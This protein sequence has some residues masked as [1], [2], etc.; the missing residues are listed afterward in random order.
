MA[1]NNLSEKERNSSK[2][3]TM[4]FRIDSEIMRNISDEA[5]DAR[6]SVNALVNQILSRYSEWGVKERKAGMV[7]VSKQLIND[8]FRRITSEEVIMMAKDT[9][10][11]AVYNIALFMKGK[12]DTA[13]F[14]D[15]FLARMKTC[16]E[17]SSIT[18]DDD[19]QTYILKHDLGQNWSLYNKTVLELIFADLLQ[20]PLR[21]SI[22]DSTIVI[23]LVKT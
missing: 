1:S 17:I 16:S 18:E 14:L 11:N 7:P 6:L 13:S 19:S 2:T 5:A 23:T 20:K 4:T 22:T 21:V 15:W 8:M 9:G 10:K 12:T 3:T